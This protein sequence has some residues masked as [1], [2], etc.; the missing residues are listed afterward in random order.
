MTSDDCLQ[1]SLYQ[2]S[3]VT[4]KYNSHERKRISMKGKLLNNNEAEQ[5]RNFNYL[6]W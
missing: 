4:L 1:Q 3:D 2:S 6:G 5:V